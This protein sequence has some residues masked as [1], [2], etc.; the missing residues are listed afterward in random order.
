MEIPWSTLVTFG[1]GKTGQTVWPM[2]RLGK[3]AMRVGADD[4]ELQF[5]GK[6]GYRN[7]KPYVKRENQ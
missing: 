2:K 5:P 1:F 6:A 7:Y 3:H 4:Q